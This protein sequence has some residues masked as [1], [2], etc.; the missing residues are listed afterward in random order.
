MFILA[1]APYP[2]VSAPSNRTFLGYAQ[3]QEKQINIFPALRLFKSMQQQQQQ[4]EGR[5]ST[6]L[7]LWCDLL[8]FL[9]IRKSRF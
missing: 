1:N 5:L 7:D 6:Q 3:K 9:P 8:L 2:F 4:P